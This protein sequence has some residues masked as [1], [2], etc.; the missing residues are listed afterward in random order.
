MKIHSRYTQA[1]LYE[2]EVPT[3]QK[4]VETAVA[5]DADLRGADLRNADLSRADLRDTDLSR[6]DLSRADLSGTDLSD[7]YLRGTP[8][9]PQ[10][11]TLQRALARD[12][13][14]RGVVLY[15]TATSQHISNTQYVPG[16]TY[17]APH[18]SFSAESACH[19]GIYLGTLPWMRSHYPQTPLVRVY[20]RAGDYVI[21]SKGC[22]RAKRIRVLSVVEDDNAV[23]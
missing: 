12:Q 16:H 8:L 21:C 13:H 10:M 19:P 23:H 11:H 4:L 20:C 2:A 3:I 17:I 7:T 22:F 18:L 6:A 9:D 15:R 1:T 5:E 14:L